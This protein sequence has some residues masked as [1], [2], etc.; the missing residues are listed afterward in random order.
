MRRLFKN[1]MR[2]KSLPEFI[3]EKAKKVHCLRVQLS[4]YLS[5]TSLQMQNPHL[6]LSDL[7]M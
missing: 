3:W 7:L 4:D 6:L 5:A 1:E 2:N